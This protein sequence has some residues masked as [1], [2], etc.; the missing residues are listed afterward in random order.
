MLPIPPPTDMNNSPHINLRVNC[1]GGG[2]ERG[3]RGPVAPS[4]GCDPFTRDE[5]AGPQ[6]LA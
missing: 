6:S 3:D 4:D 2:G 1:L 5:A